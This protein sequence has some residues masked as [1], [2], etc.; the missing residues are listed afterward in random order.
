MFENDEKK[1]GIFKWKNGDVYEGDFKSSLMDGYGVFEYRDGRRYEGTWVGGF[2]HGRGTLYVD[3][4][5][6][7]LIV[8][9]NFLR[10]Y[11]NGDVYE[12]EFFKVIIIDHECK[13]N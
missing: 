12:G 2:K 3:R 11:P 7:L 13:K 4:L 5:D 9:L 6:F 8:T 10:R 1:H